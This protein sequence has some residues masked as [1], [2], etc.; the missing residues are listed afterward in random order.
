[1]TTRYPLVLNGTTIQEL[2]SGDGI[3]GI[4]P[5]DVGA[6]DVTHKDSSG[7]YAGLTLYKLNLKN[8]A[9]TFTNFFTNATTAARTWALPDKDGTVAMLSDVV[10]SG[11]EVA[12]N[13]DASGGYAG[14]TLFKLNLKNA[15]NTFTNFFTNA[16]TAA[17][18]WTMPDKDGTVA[19]MEDGL[20]SFRN[21]F[22]N[23]RFQIDQRNSGA[24]QTITAGAA[25]A[26]T[27][28]RWFAW[29][30]GANVTGQQLASGASDTL[31]KY[32]FTGAASVTGIN[33]AQR[34]KAANCYDLAGK[35]CTLAVET[36]NSLL[37]TITWTAY[38]ANT[39]NTFGSIASPTK[40]QFSTGT[41]TVS[42]TDTRY[43]AQLSVPT[44]AT[45]GIEIV[46][47]VGAQT[48]GTWTLEDAQLELGTVASRIEDRMGYELMLCMEH[49]EAVDYARHDTYAG[50]AVNPGISQPF[51]VRK[52]AIPS[53]AGT[54][55]FT[56][57]NANSGAFYVNGIDGFLFYFTA[58]GVGASVCFLSSGKVLFI[59]EI[60]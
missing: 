17:R 55:G 23:P 31:N 36:A 12:A 48:S 43:S 5:G 35:T 46:F 26:Y 27:I 45:N 53:I 32:Q 21:R 2:Q 7:G 47:S 28:D 38:Y 1:M 34:I 3:A 14:L 6:E 59:A 42:S 50:G 9:G 30:T 22:T 52:F 40:T 60:P 15:A 11:A 19:L 20:S 8:A 56:Y 37:T 10:I 44:N 58:A 51:K 24:A 41:F 25:L 13:K 39:A 33:F 18:T 16:T 49:C 57:T 54:Y 4:T 29:C